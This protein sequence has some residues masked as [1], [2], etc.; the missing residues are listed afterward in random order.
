[1]GRAC[2]EGETFLIVGVADAHADVLAG[3]SRE[4]VSAGP[5]DDRESTTGRRASGDRGAIFG[6]AVL[7]LGATIHVV[8][9]RRGRNGGAAEEACDQWFSADDQ[10][11]FDDL[12]DAWLDARGWSTLPRRGPRDLRAAARRRAA[13]VD[14][15]SVS[16]SELSSD[17]AMSRLCDQ[18]FAEGAADVEGALPDDSPWS[19][20]DR[21]EEVS[22]ERGGGRSEPVGVVESPV[23]GRGRAKR[24]SSLVARPR[25]TAK[26]ARTVA[27]VRPFEPLE[28]Q[29][30][31]RR[32]V[33]TGC[34]K[35]ARHDASDVA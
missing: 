2:F 9:T 12:P 34:R 5:A 20:T 32:R 25:S 18:L 15:S 6:G 28:R 7:L 13:G 11:D 17:A 3:G 30:V 35:F 22:R 27:D 16:V 21:A 26:R 31:A 29:L 4:V 24:R 10:E 1:M 14:R 19:V 23:R 33:A 8:R